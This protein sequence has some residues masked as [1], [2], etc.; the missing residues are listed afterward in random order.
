[1]FVFEFLLRVPMSLSPS[2]RP[3]SSAGPCR[4]P[5][6]FSSVLNILKAVQVCAKIFKFPTF[7]S[8]FIEALIVL[9]EFVKPVP[10]VSDRLRTSV[11]ISR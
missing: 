8:N 1:M 2:E 6:G 7:V 4:V 11:L 3:Q 10:F 9:A 5:Q